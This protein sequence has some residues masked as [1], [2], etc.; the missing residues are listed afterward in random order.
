MR[1]P[2]KFASDCDS[3]LGEGFSFGVSK[4]GNR[5]LAPFP[6]PG[7]EEAADP[8]GV[9]S[10]RNERIRLCGVGLYEAR[11][12]DFVPRIFRPRTYPECLNPVRRIK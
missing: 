7:C 1:S 4:I 8:G 6:S 10:Q 3:S 12:V 5:P 2:L 9:R 11:P